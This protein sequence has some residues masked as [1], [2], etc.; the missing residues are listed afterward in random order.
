MSVLRLFCVLMMYVAAPVS[1][2]ADRV[3]GTVG[4]PPHDHK[5]EI[6]NSEGETIK[7]VKLSETGNFKVYL[8]PGLYRAKSSDG[9]EAITRSES[10]PLIVCLSAKRYINSGKYGP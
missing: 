5:F 9:K 6:L 3:S 1:V 2:H 8:K 7:T 10:V 4:P